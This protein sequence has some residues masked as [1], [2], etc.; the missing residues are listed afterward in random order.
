MNVLVVGGTRFLGWHIV[1]RLLEDGRE[2]TLFNRG[3]TPDDFGGE[4]R[5]LRGDRRDGC[6]FRVLAGSRDWDAVVDLIAYDAGDSRSAVDVFRERVGHFLH[7]STGAVYIVT[8]DYPCPLREEDYDRE[9]SPRPAA[10]DGLWLYGTKKREAED[11]LNAAHAEHG[12]PATSLR[13]PIVLGERDY[14][15]RAYS[16]FLRVEDG[17]TVILPDG[18]LCPSTYVYA[19][20]VAAAVSANLGNAASFGRAYNLAQA[21]IVSLREFVRKSASALGANPEIA[22]IPK[23]VLDRTGWGRG[24]SPFS[25]RRPFVLSIERAAREWGFVPSPF[26]EWLRA[27]AL[28]FRDRYRGPLPENYLRREEE[29]EMARRYADAVSRLF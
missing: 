19:G 16:Y 13:L 9:L 29:A 10:D 3:L 22:D 14:T 21:E 7:I 26:D 28:W 23:D 20:D 12:F 17:K 8:R 11:V 5:R 2:V 4:V 1:R 18:G 25:V 24:F 15:L 6:A 27:T